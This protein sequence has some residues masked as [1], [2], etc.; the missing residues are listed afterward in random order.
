MVEANVKIE[1]NVNAASVPSWGSC[2]YERRRPHAIYRIA[3]FFR[4]HLFSRISAIR[5]ILGATPSSRRA[6]TWVWSGFGPI[7]KIFFAK[8]APVSNLRKY[9]YRIYTSIAL[10]LHNFTVFPILT[11]ELQ[12]LVVFARL[13]FTFGT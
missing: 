11:F 8:F 13:H 3:G 4:G 12:E 7:A 10:N 5:E 9:R 6:P 2:Y 1:A